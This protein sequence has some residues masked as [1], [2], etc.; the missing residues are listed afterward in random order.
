MRVLLESSDACPNGR[1]DGNQQDRQD[2]HNQSSNV[3]HHVAAGKQING[4]IVQR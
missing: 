3:I 1:D 2:D 4:F